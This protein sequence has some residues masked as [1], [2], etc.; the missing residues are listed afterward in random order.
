M[1]WA[2]IKN[3]PDSSDGICK[4]G[5][6]IVIKQNNSIWGKGELNTNHFLIVEWTDSA[7]E[8]KLAKMKKKG[9]EFPAISYP[10]SEQDDS[11]DI[12]TLTASTEYVDMDTV[13]ISKKRTAKVKLGKNK[14]RVGVLDSK[15][16]SRKTRSKTKSKLG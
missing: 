14:I 11:E 9:N 10:Y 3:T 15:T 16:F 2:L 1:A 7:I 8:S 6:V 4:R 12:S 5:D 13:D